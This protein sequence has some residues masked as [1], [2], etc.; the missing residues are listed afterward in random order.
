M[1]LERDDMNRRIIAGNIDRDS[2]GSKLTP[3]AREKAI[4][5]ALEVWGGNMGNGEA[6][7]I[8][9]KHATRDVFKED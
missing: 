6:A 9:I 3:V 5:F 4:D 7:E 1:A 8:G 2:V